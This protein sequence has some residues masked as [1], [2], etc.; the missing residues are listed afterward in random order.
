MKIVFVINDETNIKLSELAN[1]L[2]VFILKHPQNE[3]VVATN[4]KY[5]HSFPT[6]KANQN[7]LVTTEEVNSADYYFYFGETAEL[8]NID[9]YFKIK[10]VRFLG[11]DELKTII[12]VDENTNVEALINF[13]QIKAEDFIIINDAINSLANTRIKELEKFCGE[14]ALAD[15]IENKASFIIGEKVVID[16]FLDTLRASKKELQTYIKEKL[17]SGFSYRISRLF[18]Q[19]NPIERLSAILNN[20]EIEQNEVLSS[21]STTK[22]VIKEVV[23]TNKLL[24]LLSY[25][26]KS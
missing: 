10:N 6:L 7:F 2:R 23:D 17:T 24:K 16:I 9:G 15:V 14:V 1:A 8:M 19:S 13:L 11:S 22:I 26:L 12:P 25:Y 20:F 5:L 3:V 4:T 21:E 18:I